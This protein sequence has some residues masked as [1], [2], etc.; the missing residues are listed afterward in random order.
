[1]PEEPR[2]TL[3]DKD[4]VR[5]N[6]AACEKA[7]GRQVERRATIEETRGSLAGVYQP[8]ELERLREDWPE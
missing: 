6:P 1:M 4:L 3:A 2:H 7:I 5:P 8:N